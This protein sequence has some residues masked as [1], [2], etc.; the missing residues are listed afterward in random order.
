LAFVAVNPMGTGAQM[1]ELAG[2]VVHLFFQEKQSNKHITVKFQIVAR[3]SDL[4]HSCEVEELNSKA[5]LFLC[6]SN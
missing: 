2:K 5:K 6:I 4:S 1:R 3:E